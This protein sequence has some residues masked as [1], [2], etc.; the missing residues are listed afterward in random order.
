MKKYIVLLLSLIAVSN[1]AYTQ[2]FEWQ[3]S[4]LGIADNRE[5]F[6]S[7]HYPQT[8]LGARGAFEAGLRFEKEHKLRFGINYLYEYGAENLLEENRDVTMYYAFDNENYKIIAGMFS[9]KGRL[10]YP[11]ALLTDTLLYYRPNVEGLMAQID[12]K[13]FTQNLWADWT[14]RQT[15]TIRETFL[16][17]TSGR[18][19]YGA[20]FIENYIVGYHR[21]TPMIKNDMTIRDNYGLSLGAGFNLSQHTILDSLRFSFNY[22]QSYDRDRIDGIWRTPKGV[23]VWATLGY[24]NY[25]FDITS[26]A[27]DRQRLVWG[28]AFFKETYYTRI[29]MNYTLL[30]Y[31]YV[32]ADFCWTLHIAEGDLDNQQRLNIWVDIGGK[33][34]INQANET[35]KTK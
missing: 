20:F 8:I 13:H 1:T 25:R 18:F 7:V 21:A 22:L 17:G 2:T 24:K 33:S 19:W 12:K 30:K 5:Y 14:S 6:N 27:G 16:V 26:Y 4:F 23:Y 10:N 9:R 32:H 11:L 29:D 31:K 15:D 35:I 34:R 28:D 3:A